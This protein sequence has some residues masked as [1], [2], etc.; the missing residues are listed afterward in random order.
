MLFALPLSAQQP[1]V[2]PLPDD[3][4][5]VITEEIHLNV[6]VEGA[7][8]GVVPSLRIDDLTVIEDGYFTKEIYRQKRDSICA[9]VSKKSI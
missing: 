5:K 8:K 2:S 6:Y 4:V 1:A 9:T 7:F 3:A